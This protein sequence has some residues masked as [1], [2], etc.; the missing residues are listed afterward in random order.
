MSPSLL[1]AIRYEHNATLEAVH[2]AQAKAVNLGLMLLQ[3]R[4][5][6]DNSIQWMLW[7]EHECPIPAAAA[8]RYTNEARML[9]KAA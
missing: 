1:D 9:R 8:K 3:I 2:R 7:L 4:E 6:M 5:G